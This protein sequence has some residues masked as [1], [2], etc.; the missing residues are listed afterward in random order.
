MSPKV[1]DQEK[2]VYVKKYNPS[3]E[4]KRI[5]DYVMDFAH[6]SEM[7]RENFTARWKKIE[8]QLRCIHPAEWVDK[9][10]WQTRVFLPQA[11]KTSETAA[12]KLEEILYTSGRNYDIR[13][14]EYNDRKKDGYTMTLIDNILSRGGYTVQRSFCTQE[15]IDIGTS[16]LKFTM[17]AARD[18]LIFTWRSVYNCLPDPL[19]RHDFYKSKGWIDVIKKDLGE[20]INDAQTNPNALYSV[21]DIKNLINESEDHAM[22]T[23]SDEELAMIR[24]IDNTRDVYVFRDYK[25]VTLYEYWGLVPVQRIATDPETGLETIYYEYKEMQVTIANGR[26]LIRK[27]SNAEKD[28][29]FGFIPVVLGRTKRRKFDLFGKG[30]FDNTTDLQELMNSMVCLGFDSLKISGMDIVAIDEDKVTDPTSIVYD[31]MAIWKG[32]GNP[33]EW[34][35]IRRTGLSAMS[36]IMRG[37]GF[38]DSIYQDATGVTRHA[39]G[40]A[41]TPG[42]PG[43][44]TETLGEYEAKSMQVDKRFLQQAKIIEEEFILPLIRYIYRIIRNP[45]LFKQ[46]DIDRILGYVITPEPLTNL[47]GETIGIKEVKKTPKLLQSELPNEDM[48]LD[49]TVF[50]VSQYYAKLELVNTFKQIIAMAQVNPLVLQKLDFNKIFERYFQLL[51]VPDYQELIKVST[52]A[53]IPAAAQ[54]GNLLS[55][56]GQTNPNQPPSQGNPTSVPGLTAG[57]S[58]GTGEAS[59]NG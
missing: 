44:G 35:D 22:T 37:L 42:T 24:D 54:L 58:G 2:A 49:F 40:A 46:S 47:Q 6:S 25:D 10:N 41:P 48:Q 7:Y 56:G 38:I 34:V 18:G 20:L 16:F 52:D 57:A 3:E 59:I 1:T 31:P 26:C 39:Q 30:Y 14:V 33:R 50:G 15:F 51:N 32:K 19:A 4:D 11:A 23:K 53:G 36:D 5:I 55:G 29:G 28:G 9:K 43:G 12:S 13:G 21:A 27:V 8:D 17:N 45:K